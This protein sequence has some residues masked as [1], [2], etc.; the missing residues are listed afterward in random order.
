ME[1]PLRRV[2]FCLSG[3]YVLHISRIA[4]GLIQATG[5]VWGISRIL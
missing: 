2:F 3:H 4:P 1:N 5:A